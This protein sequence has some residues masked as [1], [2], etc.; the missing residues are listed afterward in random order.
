MMYFITL[1]NNNNIE[2]K[3]MQKNRMLVEYFVFIDLNYDYL[4]KNV[5]FL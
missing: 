5:Y 1:N 3:K 2:I 4:C